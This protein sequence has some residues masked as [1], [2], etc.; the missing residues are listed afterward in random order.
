M[1]TS[2]ENV[3]AQAFQLIEA[4]ACAASFDGSDHFITCYRNLLRNNGWSDR[5]FDAET[6]RRIDAD[7]FPKLYIVTQ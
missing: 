4:V 2:Y 3:A 1:R 5:D 6:L 7:W